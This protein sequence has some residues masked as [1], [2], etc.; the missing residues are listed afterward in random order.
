MIP[1]FINNRQPKTVVRNTESNWISLHQSVPQGTILGPILFKLYIND[2]NKNL[3]ESC[4][5]VQ[6]ADD[7]L[8]FCDDND[9]K[10]AL[11]LLQNPVRICLCTS[12]NIL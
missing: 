3:T 8:L 10:N 1:C 9:I 6:Y 12:Q 5:V 11:Q 2:L 4:K 7:T